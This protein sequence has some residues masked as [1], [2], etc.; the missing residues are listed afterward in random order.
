MVPKI[1]FPQSEANNPDAGILERLLSGL[2]KLRYL[3]G[4]FRIGGGFS[5][6]RV[7]IMQ[8]EFSGAAKQPWSVKVGPRAEIQPQVLII[9][10]PV[11][12]ERREVVDLQQGVPVVGSFASSLRVIL[13]HDREQ[14]ATPLQLQTIGLEK[15]KVCFADRAFTA[16][17]E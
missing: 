11:R 7:Y 2:P 13:G 15:I 9:R 17:H 16:K 3:R 10:F 14:H 4:Q 5:S 1:T 12:N 6:C 8:A